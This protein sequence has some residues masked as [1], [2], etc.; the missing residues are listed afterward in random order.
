MKQIT[1]IVSPRRVHQVIAA[2]RALPHFPGYTQLLGDGEGRGQ[3]ADGHY[4][5]DESMIDPHPR[6]VLLI[7]CR[8][9]DADAIADTIR[10]AAHS[11]LAGDGMIFISDLDRVIRIRSGEL[12]E[13]AV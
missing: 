13:A 7:A 2:L 4:V 12:N 9:H 1:A 5:P 6:H 8:D 10:Q 11:G 3:G